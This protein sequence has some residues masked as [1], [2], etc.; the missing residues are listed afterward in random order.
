MIQNKVKHTLQGALF[1]LT[2]LCYALPSD[3]TALIHLT[4]DTISLD[5]HDH[6]G[7][8]KGHV[9]LDQGST[10]LRA[11]QV[12]TDNDDKNRLTHAMAMGEDKIQAH[13]WTLTSEDKPEVHAYA[14]QL[15]YNPIT[16]R[17]LL[18]GHARIVQGNHSFSAPHIE[19]DT[20]TEHVTTQK[21]GTSRTTIVIDPKLLS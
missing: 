3:R 5:Q 1:F 6:H 14:D 21:N 13:L 2:S 10:H 8:Y 16:H 7:I 11:A 17:I 20:I 15:S 18:I 12:I 4:A 19:Y 9:T